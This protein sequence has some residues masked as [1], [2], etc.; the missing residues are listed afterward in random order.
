MT[1]L[2]IKALLITTKVLLFGVLLKMFVQFVSQCNKIQE[3]VLL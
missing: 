3:Q 2:H 1:D